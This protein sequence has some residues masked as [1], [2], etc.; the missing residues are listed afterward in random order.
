MQIGFLYATEPIRFMPKERV[1]PK[2]NSNTDCDIFHNTWRTKVLPSIVRR[3]L[4]YHCP[5]CKLLIVDYSRE[6]VGNE[7][8]E[9]AR[10]L[11]EEESHEAGA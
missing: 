5:A 8:R 9:L 10:K 1:I 2:V 3:V 11:V 7:S 4:G 6:F